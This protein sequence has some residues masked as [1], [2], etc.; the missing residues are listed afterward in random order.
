MNRILTLILIIVSL[1]TL[2]SC[3]LFGWT[4]T[5]PGMVTI[6][7]DM[8]EYTEDELLGVAKDKYS[9]TEWIF[10]DAEIHEESTKTI[11]A[12][13]DITDNNVYQIKFR[14]K[15]ILE[16]Y[17]KKYFNEALGRVGNSNL[18]HTA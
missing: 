4:T 12:K 10:T 7:P 11:A 17:G 14:I 8:V 16:K 5:Y 2:S 1:F 18:R 15:N 3:F 9:V 13:Y 6:H